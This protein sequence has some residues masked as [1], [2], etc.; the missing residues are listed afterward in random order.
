MADEAAVKRAL[1]GDKD[2]KGLDLSEAN[3]NG[4]DLSGADLT[5][6]DL[7]NANLEGANLSGANV[8]GASFGGALYNDNTKWPDG[9][10]PIAAWA[11]SNAGDPDA[12]GDDVD[13]GDSA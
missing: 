10:D 5:D 13:R 7:S 3:L 12:L 11:V 2:L 1:A 6:A 4:A 8:S 9:F